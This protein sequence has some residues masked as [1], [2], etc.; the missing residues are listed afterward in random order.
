VAAGFRDESVGAGCDPSGYPD[1]AEGLFFVGVEATER[2]H[3]YALDHASGGFTR[4]SIIPSG[5]A[6]VMRLDFDAELAVLWATCDDGCDGRAAV[7]QIDTT[8]GSATEGRF[9]VSQL[10]DRPTGIPNVNNE[11]FALTPLAECVGGTRPVF[12]SDDDE[13]V[14]HALRRGRLSCPTP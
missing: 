14:G 9:V 10:L 5:L 13:T 8:A 6:G 2:I 11:G 4:I 1:H 12:G 7:L 3:A